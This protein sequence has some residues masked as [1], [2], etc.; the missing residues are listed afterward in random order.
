MPDL[1]T[2]IIQYESGTMTDEQEIEFFQE[3]IDSG[4][5]WKLQGSYGRRAR[6]FIED[7]LCTQSRKE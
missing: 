6:D 2:K 5:C 1:V 4:L 3:L 7:G